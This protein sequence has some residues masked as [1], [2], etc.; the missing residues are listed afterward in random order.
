MKRK[1][2]FLILFVPVYYLVTVIVLQ[3]YWFNYNATVDTSLWAKLLHVLAF[4]IS[5]PVLIPFIFTDLG[6]YWPIWAQALPFLL[7]GLLWGLV[8]LLV[9]AATKRLRGKKNKGVAR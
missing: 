1:I 8:I 6:E 5:V 4:V 9:S 7:N 2:T 3:H